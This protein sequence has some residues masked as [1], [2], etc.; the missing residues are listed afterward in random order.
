MSRAVTKGTTAWG[1]CSSARASRK[2]H[3]RK[4]AARIRPRCAPRSTDAED[5]SVADLPTRVRMRTRS[6]THHGCLEYSGSYFGVS[7]LTS[8]GAPVPGVPRNILRPSGNVRSLPFA[9]WDLSFA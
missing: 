5:L 7:D 8:Y 1:R 9:L 6:E 3:S 2:K 4:A